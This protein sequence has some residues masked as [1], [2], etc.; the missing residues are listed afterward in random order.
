MSRNFFCM[1]FLNAVSIW[2]CWWMENLDFLKWTTASIMLL[3]FVLCLEDV[4][5]S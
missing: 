2:L 4:V 3:A 1:H 5:V